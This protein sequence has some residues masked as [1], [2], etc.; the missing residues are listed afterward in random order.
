MP[1]RL[2]GAYLVAQTVKN[3]PKMQETQIQALGQ[4]DPLEKEMHHTPVCLPG[5]F[6]GQRSLEG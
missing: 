5:E 4:D 6:H 3:L 2:Y 1:L